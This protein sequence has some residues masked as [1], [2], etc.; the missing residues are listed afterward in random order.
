[1]NLV[2]EHLK[3][4]VEMQAKHHPEFK[5]TYGFVLEHGRAFETI[6]LPEG[7]LRGASKDCFGNAL[8]AILRK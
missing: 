5:T 4:I 7:I 3:M 2:Q 1:M 6:A 8:R